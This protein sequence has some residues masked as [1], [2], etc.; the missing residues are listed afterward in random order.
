MDDVISP[1]EPYEQLRKLREIA[2][3]DKLC[4]GA[5]GELTVEDASTT[6][7]AL[8]RTLRRDNRFCTVSALDH[9]ALRVFNV[10]EM[11]TGDAEGMVTGFRAWHESCLETATALRTLS[12]TY[13]ATEDLTTAA[14]IDRATNLIQKCGVQFG[15]LVAA[16]NPPPPAKVFSDVATQTAS[17]GAHGGARVRPVAA[18]SAAPEVIP[19]QWLDGD[20]PRRFIGVSAGCP[21]GGVDAAAGEPVGGPASSPAALPVEFSQAAMP[22]V[23]SV[24]RTSSR[25]GSHQGRHRHA[26]GQE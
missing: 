24:T 17:S 18:T 12:R 15:E 6:M 22:V 8:K 7:G 21:A 20:T 9:F 13:R 14:S 19:P 26:N 10:L 5:G 16:T 4:L 23:G 1:A 25:G 11:A 2:P 3:G